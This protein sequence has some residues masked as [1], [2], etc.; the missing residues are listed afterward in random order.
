MISLGGRASRREGFDERSRALADRLRQWD[1]LGVYA[2]EIRPSDDEEYDDLV[3]PL[4]AW[5]EA[6]ASPE[7]LS[8][9]LVGVLRQ[10][11][12]LSVPDDSAEIAFAREV[13]AWWTTLS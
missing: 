5:L 10:W 8:T 4:R 3:A 1:V 9:G 2:D 13:H 7:E 12:G 11:Y 6:G